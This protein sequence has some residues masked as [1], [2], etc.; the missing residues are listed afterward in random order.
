[1]VTA[2]LRCHRLQNA[3][4]TYIL[5]TLRLPTVLENDQIVTNIILNAG[6]SENVKVM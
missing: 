3:G 2:D 4:P 5:L 1:M 6:I